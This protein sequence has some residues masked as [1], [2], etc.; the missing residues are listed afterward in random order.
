M[1]RDPIVEEVRASRDAFAKAHDYDI[2]EIFAALRKLELQNPRRHVKIEPEPAVP[3]D[4][5]APRP[6]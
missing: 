6:T 5:A 4:E 3:R 2:D 1:T